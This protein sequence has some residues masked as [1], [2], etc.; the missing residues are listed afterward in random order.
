[1]RTIKKFVIVCMTAA[2][3]TLL[4][5]CK[6]N[7]DSKE[8]SGIES[9]SVTAEVSAW[10]KLNDKEKDFYNSLEKEGHTIKKDTGYVYIDAA[11]YEDDHG[12]TYGDDGIVITY[13]FGDEDIVHVPEEID[14]KKV[15]NV[16]NALMRKYGDTNDKYHNL[17]YLPPE[18]KELYFPE[19][20]QE[21]YCGFDHFEALEKIE[22]PKSQTEIQFC[23]FGYCLSL[24]EF[25]CPDGITIIDRRAFESCESMMT[26]TFNNGLKTIEDDAFA[27]C[28]SLEKLEFPDTL[29]SIGIQSFQGCTSLKE[30][31]IPSKVKTIPK[32]AFFFCQS[33]ETVNLPEGVTTINSEAF[34]RCDNLKEIYIPE[35]VTEI[36][37]NAFEECYD[38]SIK[39]K[40]GSYAEEYAK[41]NGI[42]FIAE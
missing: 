30:V 10:D 42:D 16:A 27:F 12:R 25:T 36:A 21:I 32:R 5:S 37:E 8:T 6:K 19:D 24:K 18:I 2:T 40:S 17:G 33:L 41:E 34:A 38:L 22:L 39:G 4:F 11:G 35:S 23:A 31:N 7:S 3:A 14:G 15:V 28:E 26:F 20:F 9:S 13:W 1:M 29:E